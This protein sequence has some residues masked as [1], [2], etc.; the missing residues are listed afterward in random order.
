M[1]SHRQGSQ[2]N[3]QYSTLIFGQGKERAVET[4]RSKG[5]SQDP[6]FHSKE[7][8]I[9]SEIIRDKF[10]SGDFEVPCS[11][12]EFQHFDEKLNTDVRNS[13]GRKR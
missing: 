12:L 9:K 3:I 1:T 7:K 8:S 11:R 6:Y 5:L 10:H 13:R 4:T 2:A